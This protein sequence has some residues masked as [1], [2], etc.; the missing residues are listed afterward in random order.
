MEFPHFTPIFTLE[1]TLNLIKTI[2]GK[3]LE[4][5]YLCNQRITACLQL[6]EKP[7]SGGQLLGWPPS[8]STNSGKDGLAFV[9]CGP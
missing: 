1:F 4:K 2:V 7:E 6:R 9:D 8:F 3:N 5:V